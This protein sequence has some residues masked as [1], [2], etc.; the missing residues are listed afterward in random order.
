MKTQV[1][2]PLILTTWLLVYVP[3]IQAVPL[4]KTHSPVSKADASNSTLPPLI[5]NRVAPASVIPSF[6]MSME[7]MISESNGPLP[8][9]TAKV[10]PWALDLPKNDT[11]VTTFGSNAGVT[12]ASTS[13]VDDAYL[14]AEL[15]ADAYCKSVVPLNI[16]VCP[17]CQSAVSDAKIETS[18]TTLAADTNGY[19]ITSASQKMIFVVFRGTNSIRS[20]IVDMNFVKTDYT[21][22]GNGAQ[23]HAGFLQSYLEVQDKVITEVSNLVSQYPDYGIQYTGHSLGAAQAVLGAMDAYQRIKQISSSNLKIHTYGEPRV[24]NKQFAAYVKSTN[25]S[26]VRAVHASDL[27]PHL[28]PM[29][30]GFLHSGTEYW[31]RDNDSKLTD[32]CQADF[33]SASCSNT[34]VPFLSITDHLSYYNINEGLCL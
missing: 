24:G 12:Q 19:I 14:R 1:L 22:V 11:S 9:G 26:K 4:G 8:N 16:W 27:V 29:N 23:V 21:P 17:H 30:M 13:Q 20:A 34:A 7:Q 15:A 32:I 25:V 6:N 5:P 18:F 2:L 10:G 33:E 28:P 3:T 31:I